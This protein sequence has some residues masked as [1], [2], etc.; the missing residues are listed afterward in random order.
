MDDTSKLKKDTTN[1]EFSKISLIGFHEIFRLSTQVDLKI[2]YFFKRVHLIIE[3]YLIKA[4][5]IGYTNEN[6]PVLTLDF[7]LV[8]AA[9]GIDKSNSNTLI[10]YVLGLNSCFRLRFANE[11][12]YKNAAMFLNYYITNSEGYDRNLM[13]VSLRND[14]YKV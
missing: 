5:E 3:P 7:D 13:G 6:H 1:S 8:T 12:I 10:L 11:E 9:I 4:F 2:G 14:L